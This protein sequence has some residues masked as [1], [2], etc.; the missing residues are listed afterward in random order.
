MP[1]APVSISVDP[2]EE[3]SVQPSTGFLSDDGWLFFPS[4]YISVPSK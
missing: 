2:G 4:V 3:F 1:I